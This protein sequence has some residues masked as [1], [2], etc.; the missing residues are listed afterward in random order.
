MRN[1]EFLPA[2]LSSRLWRCVRESRRRAAPARRCLP[3]RALS[4]RVPKQLGGASS[5]SRYAAR[6]WP[7]WGR[8]RWRRRRAPI[9]RRRRNRRRYEPQQRLTL[10]DTRASGHMAT[11]C[12]AGSGWRPRRP[13]VRRA[14]SSLEREPRSG[15]D[16]E[17]VRNARRNAEPFRRHPRRRPMHPHRPEGNPSP[18]GPLG[19]GEVSGKPMGLR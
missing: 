14:G 3:G 5:V 17:R 13:G 16:V 1:R 15:T 10:G 2:S 8:K 19:T 9:G 4:W 11:F 6:P 18:L 12:G 7:D